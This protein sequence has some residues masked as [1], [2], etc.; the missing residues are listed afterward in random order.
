MMI[1]E[2]DF[3]K[4]VRPNKT[5]HKDLV[6]GI[7]DDAAVYNCKKG[8]E[9]IVC[10]DTMVEGIHFTKETMTPFQLGWKVLAANIS[11]VAAMGGKPDYYL[12]SIAMTKDWL[13]QAKG[14]Y[15]GMEA[16]AAQFGM[17]LIGGDTVSSKH[18]L[19]LSV[20]VI[21][22]V[23]ASRA[24][25]RNQ[26]RPGDA[27]LVT[28]TLGD[29]AA[30]LALL[31]KDMAIDDHNDSQYLINKHQLPL[32]QVTAAEILAEMNERFAVNDISDG[33]ASE[34]NEIAEASQVAIKINYENLPRSQ[35]LRHFDSTRQMYFMLNG[36]E[37]FQLLITAPRHKVEQ[38][39]EHFKGHDLLLTKIGEVTE[40][41]PGVTLEVNGGEERLEKAGYNH[42]RADEG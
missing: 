41:E 11:D 10:A 34:A 3:I 21:G 14:I 15:K 13:H 2:F 25:L 18:E 35:A 42:F 36:G 17:D 32:P 33:I 40:G 30:G 1:D 24:S 5:H 37:D 26:A 23:V 31:T 12:V 28:G 6:M 38:L 7:G 8:A 19:V 4:S 22:H 27:V 39:I 20:T 29:S 9:Q 16:L